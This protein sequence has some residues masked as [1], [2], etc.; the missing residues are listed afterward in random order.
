[1]YTSIEKRSYVYCVNKIASK[2]NERLAPSSMRDFNPFLKAKE[3]EGSL[4]ASRSVKI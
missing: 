2:L 4:H 1:M 3:V